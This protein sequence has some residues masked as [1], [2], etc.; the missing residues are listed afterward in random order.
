MFGNYQANLLEYPE[1]CIVLDLDDTLVKTIGDGSNGAQYTGSIN[2]PDYYSF[3]YGKRTMWG[4]KRPGCTQF[5]EYCKTRFAAIG[6]WSAG[7]SEY[8]KSIVK[9][10][11]L[12]FTPSFV[13]DNEYCEHTKVVDPTT[14]KLQ[15]AQRPWKPLQT[16]F[17]NDELFTRTNTWMLDD[18]EDY[19]QENLLNWL[20]IPPFAPQTKVDK[21]GKVLSSNGQSDDRCLFQLQEW[22]ERPEVKYNYSVLSVDKDWLA[23]ARSTATSASASASK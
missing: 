5:L 16:I 2:N 14:G 20:P 21:E 11:Q 7:R 15:D 12:P 6:I 1:Q 3:L 22:F 19:A 23:A 9:A 8:V 13:W 10:L 18:N 17:I 4:I